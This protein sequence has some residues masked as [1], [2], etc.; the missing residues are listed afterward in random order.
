MAVSGNWRRI[1][2]LRVMAPLCVLWASSSVGATPAS[3]SISIDS[4]AITPAGAVPFEQWITATS[5]APVTLPEGNEFAPT[6]FLEDCGGSPKGCTSSDEI[7]AAIV[8]R[9]LPMCSAG[10]L[11]VSASC[12]L[13]V[14]TTPTADGK[15]VSVRMDIPPLRYNRAYR[16]RMSITGKADVPLTSES[17]LRVDN[18]FYER[19]QEIASATDSPTAN[20]ICEELVDA[21]NSELKEKSVKI[22]EPL[23]ACAMGT[24]S[25]DQIRA[26]ET[27]IEDA[28]NAEFEL[29]E[30]QQNNGAGSV[31]VTTAARREKRAREALRGAIR[32][33]VRTNTWIPLPITTQADAVTARAAHIS[34]DA[35]LVYGFNIHDAITYLG[36]NIYTR[37]INTD[38]S[39]ASLKADRMLTWRH[40]FSFTL[41]ATLSSIEKPGQRKGIIGSSALVVGAGLRLTDVMRLSA[42]ALIFRSEN[43]NPLVTNDTSLTASPY[44]GISFDIDVAKKLSNVFTGLP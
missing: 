1:L 40:R 17:L 41:G 7:W 33:V 36:T 29:L 28:I 2:P 44:V 15:A 9:G 16:L 13:H 20:D 22:D 5:S 8:R 43:P 38:V 35:G 37:P 23:K 4:N 26:M 39:L 11:P 14:T 25:P 10:M 34:A 19:I 18:K 30:A 12:S 32:E 42:G 31:A 21:I 3:I 27:K 24:A 6:A